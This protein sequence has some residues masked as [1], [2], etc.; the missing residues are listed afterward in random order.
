MSLTISELLQI[1]NSDNLSSSAKMKAS[2]ALEALIERG[3]DSALIAR[4]KFLEEQEKCFRSE[5]EKEVRHETARLKEL[6]TNVRNEKTALEF[7]NNK[8]RRG[9]FA[10]WHDGEKQRLDY[11]VEQISNI[12]ESR[13][14]EFYWSNMVRFFKQF[15]GT[16]SFCVRIS[17]DKA[18]GEQPDPNIT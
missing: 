3:G 14:T 10:E 12:V 2:I 18:I 5:V 4:N 9:L 1:A 15:D 13:G 8:L 16:D 6:L 17:I 7:E 11:L